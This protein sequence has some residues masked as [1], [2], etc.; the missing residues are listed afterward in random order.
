MMLPELTP[1]PPA[2]VGIPPPSSFR[3]L[4]GTPKRVRWQFSSAASGG[5]LTAAQKAGLRYE[6]KVQLFLRNAL[7]DYIEAPIVTFLDGGSQTRRVIP[8]GFVLRGARAWI[9]EIKSQHTHAAWWQLRHLYEP[10]MLA[11]E[12]I[13]Q[14]FCVE[15]VRSYDPA[16]G[17]PEPIELCHSLDE[18]FLPSTMMKVLLWRA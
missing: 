4:N 13:Q 6:A 10:V 17:F 2:A 11:L 1:N 16:I 3:P 7:L 5:G 15:V 18:V 14:V 8:D 9:F 12:G